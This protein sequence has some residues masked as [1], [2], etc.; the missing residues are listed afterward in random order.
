MIF[1]N[2]PQGKFLLD[3]KGNIVL[4]N[5]SVA[6]V[7]NEPEV[8][9]FT[10]QHIS[11]IIKGI[12]CNENSN[13]DFSG[14]SHIYETK[15]KQGQD[16]VLKLRFKIL[17]HENDH[18][19]FLLVDD[20]TQQNKE[21]SKIYSA[22]IIGEETE[23]KRISAELHDGIGQIMSAINLNLKAI[24]TPV[25]ENW[26]SSNKKKFEHALNLT[27]IAIRELR[28]ISRNLLPGSLHDFGLVNAL[29]NLSRNFFSGS[30]LKI[31]FHHFGIKENER[32]SNEIEVSLFRIA[33]ELCNNS[34]KHGLASLV[35][36]QLI[37]HQKSL[38]LMVEDNGKGFSIESIQSNS[39]QG[40]GLQNI[41]NRTKSLKGIFEIDSTP[42]KGASI[43]VEIPIKE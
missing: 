37:K 23:R 22:Q 39:Q 30:E 2:S 18:F 35:Q 17:D 5:K 10:D 31:E 33:Q 12:N 16:I 8:S 14:K 29:K 26:D 4:A 36:M 19:I 41:H 20:V 7:F 1:H 43:T 21:Q 24:K 34:F 3:K 15:N 6:A 11:Q 32:F 27:E 38:L 28:A 40:L 42:N 9:V 13:L 25:Y